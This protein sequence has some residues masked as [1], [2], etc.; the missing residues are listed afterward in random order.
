MHNILAPCTCS[1]VPTCSSL[2]ANC[3]VWHQ[4]LLSPASHKSL[5][6]LGHFVFCRYILVRNMAAERANLFCVFLRI[7]RPTVVAISKQPINLGE[8]DDDEDDGD[9]AVQVG[10]ELHELLASIVQARC[11]SPVCCLSGGQG[12]SA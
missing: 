9:D 12:N 3:Y 11:L 5:M 1:S 8:G 7:P 10:S 6:P 4:I 2:Y